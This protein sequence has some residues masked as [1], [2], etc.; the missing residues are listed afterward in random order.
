MAGGSRLRVWGVVLVRRWQWWR[1]RDRRR[2]LA[3]VSPADPVLVIAAQVPG[4]ATAVELY[5]ARDVFGRPWALWWAPETGTGSASLTCP[6]PAPITGTADAAAWVSRLQVWWSMLRAE[7][8]LLATSVTLTRDDDQGRL[9]AWIQLTFRPG[10][11]GATGQAAVARAATEVGARIPGLIDSLVGSRVTSAPMPV[12]PGPVLAT[13]AAGYGDRSGQTA[14]SEGD[15]RRVGIHEGWDHVDHGG[16]LST[17]WRCDRV[18]TSVLWTAVPRLLAAANRDPDPGWRLTVRQE[19]AASPAVQTADLPGG[20]TGLSERS[21]GLAGGEETAPMSAAGF[22]VLVTGAGRDRADLA[23]RVQRWR[24][25]LSPGL[26]PWLRCAYGQQ[27]ASL[28][29]TLPVGLLI[30]DHAAPAPLAPGVPARATAGRTDRPI[31]PARPRRS[32]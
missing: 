14:H 5:R 2:R 32:R 26:Q 13:V 22:S 17:T 18:S 30:A 21:L 3:A 29:C 11:G 12:P 16:W 27:A 4:M 19:H 25:A 6:L 20:W 10:V 15:L 31:D 7:P 9:L 23:A 28:A 24:L 8:D 1:A